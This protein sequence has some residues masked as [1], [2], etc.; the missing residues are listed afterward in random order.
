[1][2]LQ[3]DPVFTS[4]KAIDSVVETSELT[5]TVEGDNDDFSGFTYV[6]PTVMGRASAD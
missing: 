4:E 2:L 5:K 6:A 1:L 3:I